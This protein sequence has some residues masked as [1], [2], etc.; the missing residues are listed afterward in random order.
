LNY[1]HTVG[2]AIEA[3]T[4]YRRYLH[5]EA[6]AIGMAAA[7][8]LAVLHGVLAG[9]AATRQAALLARFALPA[10][11]PGVAR[12][13]VRAAME[14]DKKAQAGR[15]AWI[16]PTTIGDVTVDRAVPDALVEAALD[17]VLTAPA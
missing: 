7:A 16:L 15:L 8:Q 5:G 10:T 6:V 3:A 13:D 4:G 1:G 17:V 12:D 14:R 2:H 9:E 11:A